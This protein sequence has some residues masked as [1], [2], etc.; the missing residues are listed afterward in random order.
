MDINCIYYELCGTKCTDNC[1][2]KEE[3][4]QR[5]M[6]DMYGNMEYIVE[7]SYPYIIV[8]CASLTQA[9]RARRK[10]YKETG[11]TS[12]IVAVTENGKDYIFSN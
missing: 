9:K 2:A 7:T 5:R 6:F 3:P 10:I 8:R 1:K 12:T 11:R 4:R